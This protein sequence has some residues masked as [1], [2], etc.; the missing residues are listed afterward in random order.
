VA[1][2]R[3]PAAGLDLLVPLLANSALARYQP[4]H[5]THAELLHRAGDDDQA[6]AA[7]SRAIALTD[8][9]VEREELERRR[10]ALGTA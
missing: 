2:A 8:N 10:D 3:G 4:L 9:Q 7:Y 1:F 5:A 6:A